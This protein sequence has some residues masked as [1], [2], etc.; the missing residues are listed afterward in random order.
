M[1]PKRNKY[2][3]QPIEV[4]GFRFDSKME[5]KRYAYW[6]LLQQAG[7]VLHIDV[8]P[9]VSLPGGIRWTLDFAVWF[10]DGCVLFEDVKSPPTANR[11]EFRRMRKQ[12][13]LLHPAAPLSV[14]TLRKKRWIEI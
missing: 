14:V 1:W 13:D 11:T 12:F 10:P 2:S 6:K 8:H 4:D 5:A 3:A 9:V 7:E